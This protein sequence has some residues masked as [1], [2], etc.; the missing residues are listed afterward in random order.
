MKENLPQSFDQNSHL[1]NS[2]EI[3]KCQSLRQQT[4]KVL[5][6]FN[7]AD[8]QSLLGEWIALFL[9]AAEMKY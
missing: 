7:L 3:I 5:V 1:E 2:L 8:P 6:V 4:T 9:K